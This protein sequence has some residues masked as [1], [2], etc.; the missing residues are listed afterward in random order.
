M[1]AIWDNATNNLPWRNEEQ[2]SK[3]WE[4]SVQSER[5]MP[6][7]KLYKAELEIQRG[8]VV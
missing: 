8:E 2:Q 5:S 3:S 7:E 1:R 4:Q 6:T